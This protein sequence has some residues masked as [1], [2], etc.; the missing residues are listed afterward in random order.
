MHGFPKSQNSFLSSPSRCFARIR[1][2][3]RF[4]SLFINDLSASLSS[5]VSCSLYVDNLVIWYPFSSVPAAVEATQKALILLDRWYKYWCL[6][7]DPSKCEVSF[8]SMNLHQA[9]LQP[10]ILLLFRSP[11][12]FNP[13]PT[14]LDV[15]FDST[16]SFSK[17]FSFSCFILAESQVLAFFQ[18]LTLYLWF[19][20]G[21]SKEFLSV[22]NEA[23]FGFFSL[24]LHLSGSF[25]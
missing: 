6:S 9:N 16:L 1:Y 12:R 11:L 25:T 24:M 7:L 19:S 4:F 22:L 3:Y 2:W 13:T 21:P 5:S 20:M 10:H 18:G 23:F 14:S 15:T 8:F 17:H